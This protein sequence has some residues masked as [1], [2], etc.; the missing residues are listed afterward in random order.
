[1]RCLAWTIV[2]VS[3]GCVGAGPARAADSYEMTMIPPLSAGIAIGVF[4][5]DVETGQVVTAWGAAKTYTTVAEAAPLPSGEYHLQLSE[6][7]DQKGV[8]NLYRIDSRSG[9]FWY[10][11]GGGNLPFT[12]NEIVAPPK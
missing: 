7:L 3:L 5:I 4:R 6:S 9:R 2:G 1:M 11:V 10:A 12:W 8:W